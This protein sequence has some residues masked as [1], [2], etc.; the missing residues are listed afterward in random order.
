MV[1]N[2]EEEAAVDLQHKEYQK[3]SLSLLRYRRKMIEKK[4][5]EAGYIEFDQ[6][7]EVP[8]VKPITEKELDQKLK[9]AL[10]EPCLLYTSPSPRDATLSRMPS[11]A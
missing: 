10:I 2:S 9:E 4:D 1:G 6:P 7:E 3:E 11:S 8:A 5:K